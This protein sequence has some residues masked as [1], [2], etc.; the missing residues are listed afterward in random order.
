MPLFPAIAI[1][2]IGYLGACLTTLCWL[3]Q[4]IK[5]IRERNTQSISLG[6]TAAFDGGVACW[7]IYGIARNDLP[8][9]LSSATTFALVTVI[10][11]LKLRLG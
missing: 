1:E 10:L 8:L 5:N 9:V 2:L 4:A 7:L 11:F 3:P 6:A